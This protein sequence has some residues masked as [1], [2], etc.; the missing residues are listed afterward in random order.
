VYAGA[1]WLVLSGCLSLLVS[2]APPEVVASLPLPEGAVIDSTECLG[3]PGQPGY[4]CV[5]HGT[6]GLGYEAAA[7]GGAARM[8]GWTEVAWD[9]VPGRV[10]HSWTLADTSVSVAFHDVAPGSQFSA[11]Y[12]VDVGASSPPGLHPR[13]SA[14]TI[15]PARLSAL[16]VPEGATLIGSEEQPTIAD[17]W[18]RVEGDPDALIAAYPPAGERVVLRARTSWSRSVAWVDGDRELSVS[19]YVGEGG[20]KTLWI[21]TFPASPL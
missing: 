8:E 13:G 7:A 1:V 4:L 9:W 11:H 18:W 19:V 20:E 14:S 6:S 5:I 21:R 10:Q 2:P 16:P 17:A 15:V 3:T 12:S